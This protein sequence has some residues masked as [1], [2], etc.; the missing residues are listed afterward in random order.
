[1]ESER[2]FHQQLRALHEVNMI[3][4]KTNSF[5]DLCRRAVEL[6]HSRLGFDRIGL[7]FTDP[8]NP[9]RMRG[10]FGIDEQGNVRDERGVSLSVP[11]E[12]GTL[13]AEIIQGKRAVGLIEKADLY[14]AHHRMVG[15]GWLAAAA[16]MDGERVIGSLSVDNLINQEPPGRYTLE[17]RRL[18]GAALGH[19]AS[20]RW[21][22]EAMLQSEKRYR[23][24]F[25]GAGVGICIVDAHGYPV[26]SN[27]AF[28]EL[29]GYS[30]EE[31]RQ[32]PFFTFTHPDDRN[33]NHDLFGQ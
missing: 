8:A 13:T 18:Y 15:T 22:E 21:A 10:A 19:L 3:L 1:E 30:D 20:R 12:T 23:A 14:D 4:T 24:I 32:I 17:L 33:E 31:L 27:P 25:E 6:A 28:Q 7:W 2:Q 5:D 16:L 9:H 29:L 11:D 26:S